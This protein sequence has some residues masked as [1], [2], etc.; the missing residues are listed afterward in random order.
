MSSEH[1]EI[2][3][4]SE[5]GKYRWHLRDMNSK[6]GTFVRAAKFYLKQNQEIL[7]GGRRYVFRSPI[8]QS[9]QGGS[10]ESGTKERQSTMQWTAVSD[11]DIG[12]SHPALVELLPSGETGTSIVLAENVTIGSDS[13]SCTAVIQN[14]PFVSK[15]HARVTKSKGGHWTVQDAGSV[16]GTWLRITSM[17]IE[18]KC[19]FQV[20]EQRLVFQPL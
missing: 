14:D 15:I 4:S 9:R 7:I 1:A 11:E 12:R 13:A 17:P 5:D 18:G 20:G 8:S 3:R 16:N 2:L 19:D 10:A 6:N